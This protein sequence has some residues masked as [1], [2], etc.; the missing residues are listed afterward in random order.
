MSTFVQE[1]AAALPISAQT[2]LGEAS[3]AYLDRRQCNLKPRSVEAYS[4]HFKT[5][6][7]FFDPDKPL[8]LFHEADFREFQN[9]RLA[10]GAGASLINHEL[11]ALAQLLQLA[12]LWN[13]IS[14][15]YERL[16]QA[17]WTPAKIM[18]SEEEERFIRIGTQ[19]KEWKTALNAAIVTGN[20]TIA[21]C[22]L[23]ML[24][25]E[26]LKLSQRPPVILV[27]PAVKNHHRVRSVP[28]NETARAAVEALV[29]EAR[30]RGACKPDHYLIPF[31]VKKASY[32]PNRP[33]GPC[34]IRSAFRAIA[35]ACG[36]RWVTPYTFRHQAIT[37]LLENGVPDETVRSIAGHVTEKAMR[38]YSHI[39]IEAKKE[40]VD[41]LLPSP[42][43]DH[44]VVQSA[45]RSRLPLLGLLK[46]K[47]ASLGL[48]I[49]EVLEVVLTYEKIKNS[50]GS[51]LF[52]M[53]GVGP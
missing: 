34:F 14:R 12:D 10:T 46:E 7:R 25:L 24:K 11:G 19:R 51:S 15:H 53:S 47:A 52:K 38:Y 28:L 37:K 6:Q 3:R 27:P 18:T 30:V 42:S 32:D 35:K 21:G 20:T 13:P 2:T 16:R 43:P 29:E 4:Y 45:A 39:R 44:R 40:A 49:D 26:H 36:L 33:A 17:N 31:R 9:W 8:G 5:L 41:R 1:L 22:E 50:R 48:G 23:R